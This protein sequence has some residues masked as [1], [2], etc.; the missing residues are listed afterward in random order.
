[1]TVARPETVVPSSPTLSTIGIPAAMPS[2]REMS[3]MEMNGWI[4]NLEII[5]IITTI[6]RT[7][8]KISGNPVI[9]SLLLFVFMTVLIV[10]DNRI[11]VF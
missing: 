8:S 3:M 5:T 2:T 7:K 6:A 9:F 1:M 4:L 10:S 11:L